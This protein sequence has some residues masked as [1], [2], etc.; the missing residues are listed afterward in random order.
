VRPEKQYMVDDIRRQV[1]GSDF[2][3]FLDYTRL[4]VERFGELRGKLRSSGAEIHV[5]KNR[6]LKLVGTGLGWGN[7]G[8]IVRQP[9]AL[10]TGK[11]DIAAA[12]VIKEF[13]QAQEKPVG[14]KGGMLKGTLLAPDEVLDIANLPS[15]QVLYA[16]LAGTLAGPMNKLVGVMNQKVLSLLFV[17]KAVEKKKGQ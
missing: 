11:D 13:A 17:L 4:T 10:V 14:I 16:Q 3:Y 12:K 5:V 7:M 6:L 1:S 15:R 9:T 8:G 2:A